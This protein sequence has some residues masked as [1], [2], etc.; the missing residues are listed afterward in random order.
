MKSSEAIC[1][2][3]KSL[4]KI[5]KPETMIH[6]SAGCESLKWSF[7]IWPFPRFYV[8]RWREHFNQHI[9]ISW[10]VVI[11]FWAV[12]ITKVNEKRFNRTRL[13]K[14]AKSGY[15]AHPGWMHEQRE[16]GLEKSSSVV[17]KLFWFMSRFRWLKRNKAARR[18]WNA[19]KY[20]SHGI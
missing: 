14:K 2:M 18:P 4:W 6:V 1:M 3:A 9:I 19:R 8:I 12:I 5:R 20:T 13:S 15:K 10:A 16:L 11:T 7:E 17:T